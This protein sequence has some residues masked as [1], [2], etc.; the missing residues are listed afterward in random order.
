VIREQFDRLAQAVLGAAR[1]TYGDRLVSLAVFGSAGR[2]TPRPDSDLDMLLV[3]RDLP[4]GRL[5]R[6]AEFGAVEAAVRPVVRDMWHSGLT[7][8]LSP[9]FK[10]PEEL[11]QGSPLLLDMV[12][13]AQVLWD[14]QG[15]LQQALGRLRARLSALGARRIW[16]GTAWHWDL[17]PDFQPGEVFELFE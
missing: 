12:D 13:D 10:T 7:V 16:S 5:A 8:E 9:V 11:Q 15:V 3:V 14:G 6:V 4:N 1:S 2:G 17:K